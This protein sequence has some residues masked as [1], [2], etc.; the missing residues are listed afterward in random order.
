MSVPQLVVIAAVAQNG[1]IGRDGQ[2]PW[3]LP[4]DLAYFRRVTQGHPVLMGRRTWESLPARFRPLPGRR[5]LVLTR[6]RGWQAEGAEAV[7]DWPTAKAL[8][9]GSEK[10]FLIGGA[11]VWASLLP[12]ADALWLTE[13][14]ADVA[15]DTHFPDWP[16]EAYRE[17]ARHPVPAAP[18]AN[19]PLA[20]VR[21]ERINPAS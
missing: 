10:V 15:G 7:P 11:E 19:L 9:A 12:E 8:L 13:V 20:F 16:R 21:Y 2:L 5:N 6:Q 14:Q 1:V 3:H 17:V 18:P 4:E